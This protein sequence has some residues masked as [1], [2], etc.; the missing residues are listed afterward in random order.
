[1]ILRSLL[2]GACSYLVPK[3]RGLVVF[4]SAFEPRRFGGNLRAVFEAMQA[5]MRSGRELVWLAASS[6]LAAELRSRGIPARSYFIRPVWMLLRA[7][8][9]VLD[10]NEPYFGLGRFRMLQLWHGTGFKRIALE[11]PGMSGSRLLAMRWHFRK[12]QLIVANCEED[13]LRKMRSFGNSNAVIL[14]SPRNDSLMSGRGAPALLQRLGLD[15]SR[16]II[17]YCPTFRDSGEA[18]PFT[19]EGWRALDAMLERKGAIL[20]VKRH[21]FDEALAVP[22]GLP[23]VRDISAQVGDVMELLA[24]TDLLVSD[25]SGIVTDFVLT[26]RPVLF[27]TYD[28]AHYQ[29]NGDRLYYNLFETLPGPFI[30][31]EQGLVDALADESWFSTAEYQKRYQAF[32]ARF[33]HYLDDQ[34]TARTV[35]ACEALMARSA[36]AAL[37]A[38]A[39][40]DRP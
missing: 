18:R 19:P 27:Y 7:E 33:H 16:K 26:G 4:Y 37:N 24:I 39:L 35:A 32:R 11:T 22:P 38:A 20:L 30:E 31:T 5:E 2:I 29:A 13:R 12:Y 28:T 25:Y 40:K 21:R 36:P 15:Q 1:M 14:G 3:R 9:I 6:R 10:K 23:H 17:S 8:W 34:S